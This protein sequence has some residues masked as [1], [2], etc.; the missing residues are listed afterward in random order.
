MAEKHTLSTLF[1]FG[2]GCVASHMTSDPPGQHPNTLEIRKYKVHALR[3]DNSHI[4]SIYHC[5]LCSLTFAAPSIE[6]VT[7]QR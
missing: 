5:I 7:E 1:F 6:E 4:D 2:H 3:N